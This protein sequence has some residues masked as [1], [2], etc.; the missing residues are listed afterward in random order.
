MVF[1]EGRNAVITFIDYSAAFGTE[2]Q[3]FL[4]GALADAGVFAAATGTVRVRLPSGVNVMSEPFNIERGVIQGDIFSPV[5]FIAS[6]G[7][8][9]LPTTGW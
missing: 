1:R 5:S 8:T 7:R 4:D 3:I 9:M 2:S 6:S